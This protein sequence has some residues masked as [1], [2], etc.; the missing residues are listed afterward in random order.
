VGAF[1]LSGE[2]RRSLRAALQRLEGAGAPRTRRVRPLLE[3]DVDTTAAKADHYATPSCTRWRWPT[4]R[5]PL[6]R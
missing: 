1:A 4:G 5:S 6:R 3:V 2:E